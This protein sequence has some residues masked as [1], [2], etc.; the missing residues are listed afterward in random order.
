[1][2]SGLGK[3]AV[4]VAVLGFVGSSACSGDEEAGQQEGGPEQTTTTVAQLERPAVGDLDA[5]GITVERV[6]PE[7]ADGERIETSRL[8]RQF[9]VVDDTLLALV[10]GAPEATRLPGGPA[11]PGGWLVERS[12]D[13][14][15]T[16]EPVDLP[17]VPG[18][19]QMVPPS[20]MVAGDRAVVVGS[21][22][23]VGD[24]DGS[25]IWT[26]DDGET[27]AAGRLDEVP[28]D[29]TLDLPVVDLADG[30]L[31]VG[32]Y[33][34]GATDPAEATGDRPQA[35]VSGDGGASW[36]AGGCPL[37]RAGPEAGCSFPDAFAGLWFSGL[38][39]SLDEGA[40]WQ[41]L[42]V[43]PAFDKPTSMYQAVERPSGGWL[44]VGGH[45][46]SPGINRYTYILRSDDGVHWDVVLDDRCDDLG[47]DEGIMSTF[48]LPVALGDKW[49]VVHSCGGARSELYLLDE[50]GTNPRKVLTSDVPGLELAQPLAAGDTVIVPELDHT[51]TSTFLRLSPST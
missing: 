8:Y 29:L 17:G 16:W 30:R 37:D 47:V 3:T 46:E 25:S 22:D 28:S 34:H 24:A 45:I 31:A 2:W 13:L 35:L 32:L 1:M 4:A 12:T 43:D 5:A 26:T 20:V 48:S 9:E 11:A 27:W 41:P 7:L 6:E 18:A 15:E 38:E 39:V 21:R 49:V 44:G 33:P 40:T 42:V 23:D 10:I 51:S 50:D 14:G 19:P 36:Q